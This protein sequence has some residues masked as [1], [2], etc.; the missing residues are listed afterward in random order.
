M[1]RT[2]LP[3]T[4]IIL[5]G[6]AQLLVAGINIYH[7]E[8][9]ATAWQTCTFHATQS[10][11]VSHHDIDLIFLGMLVVTSIFCV[12]F[13]RYLPMIDVSEPNAPLLLDLNA[14]SDPLRLL[15]RHWSRR[16]VIIY[17]SFYACRRG[18][19]SCSCAFLWRRR[20]G[21]T[22]QNSHLRTSIPHF[23]GGHLVGLSSSASFRQVECQQHV[24]HADVHLLLGGLH[25][26]GHRHECVS[27]FAKSSDMRS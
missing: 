11:A 2:W 8:W 14:A 9:E 13:N 12:F 17:L 18:S 7:P 24:L 27:C 4:H 25:I 1:S 15:D 22:L 16:C 19:Q 10:F 3:G 26:L 23:P 6:T 5:K 21:G 20:Q